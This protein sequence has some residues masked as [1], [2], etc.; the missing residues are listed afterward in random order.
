[1]GKTK[2]AVPGGT[3]QLWLFNTCVTGK[4]AA[5]QC[6]GVRGR[7]VI[8]VLVPK[9]CGAVKAA[10]VCVGASSVYAQPE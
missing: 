1:M 7:S 5:P 9:A 4:G 10:K 6:A 2:A 8:H 3:C